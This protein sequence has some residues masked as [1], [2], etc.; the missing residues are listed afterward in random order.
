MRQLWQL[1]SL[2]QD[3]PGRTED[4]RQ[5]TLLGLSVILSRCK[6]NNVTLKYTDR[7]TRSFIGQRVPYFFVNY[8]ALK[9]KVMRTIL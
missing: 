7:Y 1:K 3:F 4:E 9:F 6:P 2:P 8:S 5:E